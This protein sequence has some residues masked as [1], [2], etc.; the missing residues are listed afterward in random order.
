[1]RDCRSLSSA[2][3]CNPDESTWP[4]VILIAGSEGGGLGPYFK[5]SRILVDPWLKY[6]LC[7]GELVADYAAHVLPIWAA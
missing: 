5:N 3:S 6:L 7:G 1:M 2:T 4:E